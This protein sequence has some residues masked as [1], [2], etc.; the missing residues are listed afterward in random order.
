MISPAR[1][2]AFR[3]LELV[4]KGGYASDLLLRD[5][6]SLDSRDA[7]LASEIVFGCLRRQ[8]QLDWLIDSQTAGRKL[9]REIRIALR[10]GIYQIRH[11]DRIPAHA[12]VGESVEL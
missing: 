11:L 1:L 7:G 10:M 3:V 12:A 6:A 5:T 2:A 8:A 9:D 4:E